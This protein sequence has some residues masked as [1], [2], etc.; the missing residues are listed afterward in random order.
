MVRKMFKWTYD[1]EKE[2]SSFLLKLAKY[3]D[4]VIILKSIEQFKDNSLLT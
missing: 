2:K 4:K 3:E 1:F